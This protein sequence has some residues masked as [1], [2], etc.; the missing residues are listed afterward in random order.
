MDMKVP[1]ASHSERSEESAFLVFDCKASLRSVGSH[2]TALSF[3]GAKPRTVWCR[4]YRRG[5][6]FSEK[7]MRSRFLSRGCGSGMKGGETFILIG[8]AQGPSRLALIL[9]RIKLGLD[10]AGILMQ[11][12]GSRA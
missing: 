12:D 2:P 11:S 4:A 7:K 10:A 8:G 5:I 6:C 1:P 9:K 3:R